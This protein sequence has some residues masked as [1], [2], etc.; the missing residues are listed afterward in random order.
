MTATLGLLWCILLQGMGHF[1]VY[2]ACALVRVHIQMAMTNSIHRATTIKSVRGG[3]SLRYMHDTSYPSI[4]M[5][6]IIVACGYY[7]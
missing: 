1:L 7:N 3:G 4:H 2:P 6:K 5:Y